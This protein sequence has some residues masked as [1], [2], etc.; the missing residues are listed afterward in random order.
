[1]EIHGLME[2]LSHQDLLTHN[3]KHCKVHLGLG[4]YLQC[5]KGLLCQ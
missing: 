3:L 5:C 4:P 1:M 2:S